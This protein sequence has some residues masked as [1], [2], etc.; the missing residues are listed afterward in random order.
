MHKNYALIVF[1]DFCQFLLQVEC[2]QNIAE[3]FPTL[4]FGKSESAIRINS[5]DTQFAEDDLK[6]V[7][8]TASL[9]NALMVPKIE[10]ADQIKWVRFFIFLYFLYK[11][12]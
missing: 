12:K 4:D 8:S 1:K 11:E 7:F 10:N 5:I 2:R 6:S 9:P 3:I